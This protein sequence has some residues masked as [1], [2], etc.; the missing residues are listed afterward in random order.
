MNWREIE[1]NRIKSKWQLFMDRNTIE[2]RLRDW[3]KPLGL[4]V[5][6]DKYD[7]ETRIYLRLC[8]V[9]PSND[10]HAEIVIVMDEVKNIDRA[11]NTT[12]EAV[13]ER[14]IDICFLDDRDKSSCYPDMMKHFMVLPRNMGRT[15]ILKSMYKNCDNCG[16]FEEDVDDPKSKCYHCDQCSGNNNPSEW[17]PRKNTLDN[18]KD[19]INM[20]YGGNHDDKIDTFIHAIWSKYNENLNTKREENKTM[21]PFKMPIFTTPSSTLYSRPIPSIK[22]VIFNGPATIVIWA[23]RTK[24]VVKAQDGEPVDYEKGL[25]MAISKKALG[26]KG[27]Y[28]DQFKKYLENAPEVPKKKTVKRKAKKAE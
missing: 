8:F 19:K 12:K 4:R 21:P 18:L 17:I 1:T 9:N 5:Y 7:N 20:I 23:D 15:A 3:A 2:T 13:Y 24:T 14:L 10:K 28:F 26:N 16:R 25:A 22:D 27:N 11:I 6:T